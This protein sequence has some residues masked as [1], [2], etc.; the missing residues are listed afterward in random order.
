[1]I[2]FNLGAI[3]VVLIAALLCI[4][5][6]IIYLFEGMDEEI[7][8]VCMSWMIL[9]ASFIGKATKINGRIFFIPMW[10]LSIPVPFIFTYAIYSWTGIG[11]TFLIFI[12]F[13]G[14]L[15]GL[16]YLAE[17][18]RLD[19]LRSEKIEFPDKEADTVAYWLAVKEKFF[20]PSFLK[21]TPE[22]GRFNNRIADI[23]ERDNAE[24]TTLAFYNQEMSK[25][26]SKRKKID[27]NATKN[28]MEEIDQKIVAFK[29]EERRLLDDVLK[30]V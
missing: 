30:E 21:M 10:I 28:L 11:V 6:F 15:M 26:G 23:L 17:K 8:I 29:E 27:G 19:K 1:M 9:V 25:A 14:V 16:V 3:L 13:I 22:I 7:L 24:L 2:I 5:F 18:K 4:P 12:G 20:T